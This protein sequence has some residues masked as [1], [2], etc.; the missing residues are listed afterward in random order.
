LFA[1]VDAFRDV[2]TRHHRYY[3]DLERA[4]GHSIDAK[5]SVAGALG[6]IG[7][8]FMALAER[9]DDSGRDGCFRPE[10]TTCGEYNGALVS[11]GTALQQLQTTTI[12]ASESVE[13][14]FMNLVK[15]YLQTLTETLTV[16][17]IEEKARKQYVSHRSGVE[18]KQATGGLVDGRDEAEVQS[19][20]ERAIAIAT[21]TLAEVEHFHAER[22]IDFKSAIY[23]FLQGMEAYHTEVAAVYKGLQSHVD[24]I[25]S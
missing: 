7:G 21:V 3:H 6:S 19:M 8:L 2:V 17:K 24:R 14:V 5:R 13:G 20:R 12:P 18:R 16:L 23:A 25:P 9:S 22:I 4:L 10:C 11:V 15:W 1:R